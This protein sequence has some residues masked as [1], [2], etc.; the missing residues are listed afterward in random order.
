[1]TKHVC[2]NE[3]PALTLDQLMRRTYTEEVIARILRAEAQ[4]EVELWQ[5]ITGAALQG[6]IT[7]SSDEND[8]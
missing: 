4:R 3:P 7:S 8:R 5:W 6:Q 2:K 1:M